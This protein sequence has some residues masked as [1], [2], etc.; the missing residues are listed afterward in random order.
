MTGGLG[1]L[2]RRSSGVEQVLQVLLLFVPLAAVLHLGGADPT[3]VFITSALAIVPLAGLMGKATMRLASR[4]GEGLGGILNATFGN[5]A[6]LILASLAQR[7][8]RARRCCLPAH[9][10]NRW[11]P[12]SDY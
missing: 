1:R 12:A 9:R 7:H 2:M 6:E 4:V 11:P 5:A 10:P 3:A 8:E